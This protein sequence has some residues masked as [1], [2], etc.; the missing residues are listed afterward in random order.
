MSDDKVA[1]KMSLKD[2]EL[3]DSTTLNGNGVDEEKAEVE[4]LPPKK[5]ISLEEG[6]AGWIY[7][8]GTFFLIAASFGFLCV[9]LNQI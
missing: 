6:L 3:A 2:P 8:F 4:N 1:A 7:I 9:S 5:E